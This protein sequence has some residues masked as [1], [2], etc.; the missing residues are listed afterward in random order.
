M[1]SSTLSK[2]SSTLSLEAGVS[3]DEVAEAIDEVVVSFVEVA[4][5][6][7]GRCFVLSD[8]VVDSLNQRERPHR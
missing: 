7:L 6:Y 8:G 5:D 4:R 3:I 2:R 1:K